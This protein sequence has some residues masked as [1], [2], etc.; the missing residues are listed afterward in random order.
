MI[1]MPISEYFNQGKEDEFRQVE[2]YVLMELSQYMRVVVSTGGGI[3]LKNEN[4]G[5]LRHGNSL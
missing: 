1:E 2:Y 3:V 4:W 5:L